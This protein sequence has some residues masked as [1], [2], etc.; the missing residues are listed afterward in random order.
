M[1]ENKKLT[2]IE[3]QE[4]YLKEHPFFENYRG[5]N[6][7]T[8]NYFDKYCGDQLFYT[9]DVRV[10]VESCMASTIEFAHEFID[11]KIKEGKVQQEDF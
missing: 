3:K 8:Y 4:K 6:I 5:W 7:R 11:K 2:L 9:V 1:K 10:G